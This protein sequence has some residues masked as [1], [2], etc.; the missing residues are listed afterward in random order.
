MNT[1]SI[2]IGILIVVVF[3][4][5]FVVG[6]FSGVG[7][8][9]VAGTSDTGG[10]QETSAN[11]N[12]AQGGTAIDASQL[13]DGQKK[14]LAAMGIDPNTIVITQEMIACAEASLGPARVEEI[15]NGASPSFSEGVKLAACYR[16]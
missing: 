10:S 6:R 14:M 1:N 16:K 9:F 11:T 7:S 3:G 5:G 15:K 2:L 8:T 12:A 13:T 4:V